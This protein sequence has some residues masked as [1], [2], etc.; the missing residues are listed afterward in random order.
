MLLFIADIIG[1]PGYDTLAAYLPSL[2]KKYDVDV[3]IVNGE[4]G[5]KGKG[6]TEELTKKYKSLGVDVITGGNHSWTFA[7]FRRYLKQ[8]EHVLRPAN[9]PPEAPGKG[10]TIYRTASGLAVGVLNL[11]GRTFMYPI[12]CPFKRGMEEIEQLRQKTHI[13]LVDVHAEASAEKMALAWYFDG[14][15]S[16]VIGTHTHVQTA[17]ERILPAGTAYITDAGMTG[18]NDSV[19]GLNAEVAIK[20]FISGIPEHYQVAE[21]N[22]R[23]NGVV[24]E[25][26]VTT[27]R[28]LNITRINLP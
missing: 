15:V 1:R 20:R 19:I 25:V 26:D 9:Y 14:K 28:A 4:N 18:P 12:D 17:D 6:T 10:S 22:N 7:P 2:R 24:V 13:I 23:L 5:V 21:S 11:Q 27:G 8:A 3:C 16:A